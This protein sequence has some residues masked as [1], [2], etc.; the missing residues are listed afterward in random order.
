LIWLRRARRLIW[1]TSPRPIFLDVHPDTLVVNG[2]FCWVRNYPEKRSG[3]PISHHHR[4]RWRVILKRSKAFRARHGDVIPQT[5][6][7]SGA[8]VF[9]SRTANLASLHEMFMGISEPLIMQKFFAGC[10]RG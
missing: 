7:S 4:R 3:F 6:G 2:P 8:G 5:Y 9:S 1:A 10:E